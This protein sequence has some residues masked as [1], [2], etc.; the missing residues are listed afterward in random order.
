MQRIISAL[1]SDAETGSM[2]L[3]RAD[4]RRRAAPGDFVEHFERDLHVVLLISAQRAAHG[5]Q[6]EALGL[7]D[8]FLRE[9]RIAQTRQPSATFRR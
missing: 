6:Q 7:V 4:H 1:A 9:L 3:P 5:I 8:R 2:R